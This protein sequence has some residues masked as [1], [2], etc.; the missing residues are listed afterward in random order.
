MLN[1]WSSCKSTPTALLCWGGAVTGG[2][3]AGIE[4]WRNPSNQ[5]IAK[6]IV[7]VSEADGHSV[8]RAASHRTFKRRV[9][10]HR[11]THAPS[12]LAEASSNT[13]SVIQRL[14]P[15]LSMNCLNNWVSSFIRRKFQG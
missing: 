2:L 5:T 15:S 4:R 1:L 9:R 11:H 8:G 10:R 13:A 6:P 14:K 12:V 7:K 3:S